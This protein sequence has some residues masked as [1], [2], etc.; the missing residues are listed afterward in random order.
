MNDENKD[1]IRDILDAALRKICEDHG[2]CITRLTADWIDVS[3]P[4][5][6]KRLLTFLDIEATL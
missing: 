3:T 1:S 6:S 2:V 5:E 4:D